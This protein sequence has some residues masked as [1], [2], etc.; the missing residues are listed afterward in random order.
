MSNLYTRNGV[1]WARFKVR[2]IEYRFSLRTR[3]EQVAKKRLK[4]ERA[5]IE[6]QAVFGIAGPVSWKSAVVSWTDY[7]ESARPVGADTFDRYRTSL[8]QL[9][10]WLDQKDLHDID[11]ELL[12]DMVKGRLRQAVS[13][14]TVRRDLT[15]V[16]SVL[17]HAIDEN[18]IDANPAHAFNRKRIPENRDPIILPTEADIAYTVGPVRTRFGDMML[19]ARETGMREEEVAGLEH[20]SIDRAAR[21]ITFIG[22]RRKLRAIELTRKALTIIDRQPRNLHCPYVFWHLVDDGKGGQIASRFRNVASNFADY[23]TR[24]EARAI[25]AGIPYRRFRFHDLR[26]LYAV[27][28][29]RS[30]RGGIYDLQRNLGHTSIKTTEVY[31]AYLTPEQ[32]KAAMIGVAQKAAHKQRSGGKPPR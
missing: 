2:G 10:P 26:H 15:A 11:V 3:A 1:W 20:I 8:K 23:T 14:A 17:A 9:R 24:A 18:W 31:L 7:M 5:R 29:L 19:L 22:K 13:N 16:S 30:G 25:K 27:D 12:R 4:A 28:Y 21:V 32:A 6:D